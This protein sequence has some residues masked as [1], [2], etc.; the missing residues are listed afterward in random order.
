M[1][2]QK[3]IMLYANV[4]GKKVVAQPKLHGKCPLC[5]GD[6]FSRC[7]EINVWHWA[8]DKDNHCD[9]WYEPETEWHKTWKLAFGEKNSEIIIT[10][11][12]RRHIA[13]VFTENEVVIELQNSPIRK[14]IIEDREMFYGN[15][16]LW[17]INGIH[18]KQNFSISSS[19]I[20]VDIKNFNAFRQRNY[21]NDYKE[22][23]LDSYPEYNYTWNWARKSWTFSK[24]NVFIDFG[25]PYLVWISDGLGTSRGKCKKVNKETFLL[26]YKGDLTHLPNLV[27]E[28]YR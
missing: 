8:H 3:L 17:I 18:F 1:D 26:K 20:Y 11:D 2:I 10:K 9:Y 24:R 14:K 15:K 28:E 23:I 7:G 27:A 25:L 19:S 4:N 5:D 13:D 22:R 21:E 12:G 16:M 6:V